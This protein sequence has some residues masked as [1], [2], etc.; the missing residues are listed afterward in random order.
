M[1][2]NPVIFVFAVFC[3]VIA[4]DIGP[5]GVDVAKVVFA[6]MFAFCKNQEIPIAPFDEDRRP[7]V[8]QKPADVVEFMPRAWFI[9]RQGEIAATL[10]RTITAQHLVR[11]KFRPAHFAFCRFNHDVYPR[12]TAFQSLN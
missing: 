11:L 6:E 4:A 12:S 7:F 3:G 9:D 1:V 2:V 8:H 10:G 5:N